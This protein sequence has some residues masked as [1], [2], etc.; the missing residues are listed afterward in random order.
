MA[1]GWPL[2]KPNRAFGFWTGS[3]ANMREIPVPTAADGI[4]A[5][6]F[7]PD[8]Q[9]L[10]AGFAAGDTDVHVWD[11]GTDTETRL[12]GHSG[13]ITGLAFSRDGQT[14]ASAS[15][16]QTIRLW[17]VTRKAERR[18]FQGQYG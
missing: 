15:A 7:S 9:L 13:W 1:S 2:G 14:L 8:S 18:R 12:A 17:D 3:R 11:L 10:A 6:A 4:T 5:L 16:D